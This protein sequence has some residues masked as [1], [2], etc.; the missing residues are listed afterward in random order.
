MKIELYLSPIKKLLQ[1][2]Q[3]PKCKTQNIKAARRKY[4]Q[5][6]RGKDF[7]RIPFVQELRPKIEKW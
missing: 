1:I 2:G 7:G 6:L 4:S 5:Y 3:R